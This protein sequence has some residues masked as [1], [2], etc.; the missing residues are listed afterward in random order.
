[1]IEPL[2]DRPSAFR[3]EFRILFDERFLYIGVMAYD[4]AGARGVRVEDLRRKFDFFQNDLAGITLDPLADG[5]NSVSF[6]VTPYGAQ[7]ELQTF[8][9]EFFN[10]EWEGVWR[11]RA[12][13]S[14]SGWSGELRIPWQTLRYRADGTPWGMNLLRIARR[15]NEQ[16]AWAPYPR[17]FTVYRMDYAGRLTG[18]EPPPPRTDVQLRPYVLADAQRT[19][20]P[21]ERPRDSFDPSIGGEIIWR[22]TTSLQVEGTV[23]TDFAQADVDRQVVNL[24][25]FSVFFPERRQFFLEGAS[26]FDAGTDD[27]GLPIRPF[28]SRTIGLDAAGT[29]IPIQGGV[30]ALWRGA[31]G[32]AGALLLRQAGRDT[33][34]PATFGVLR[35][36]RNL[37]AATRVGAMLTSR[38]DEGR[39]RGDAVSHTVAVDGFS[40]FGPT[41]NLEW[42]LSAASN[43]LRDRRGVGWHSFIGRQTDALYTGLLFTGAT[44]GY[45]PAMG[46]VGRSD[47]AMV[48]PGVI[49][50]FRPAWRPAALRGFKPGGYFNL[51]LGP[52]DGRIQEGQGQL[53][54]DVVFVN[55]TVIYPYV[56]PNLQR[57]TQPVPFVGE[58]TIAPGRQDYVRYGINVSTNRSARL[59]TR[60]DASTGGF[61]NGRQDRLDLTLRWAPRPHVSLLAN[62]EVNR[63]RD[64]GAPARSLTTHLA[65]P[66]L[67]LAWNPRLQ[68]SSFYQYSSVD[69]RGVFNG[70]FSWEFAPL[71]YLFVV[72]NDRRQQGTLPPTLQAFPQSNELL[73]KLVYLWQ[74]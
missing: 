5:R 34:G 59:S 38:V 50:D 2:Q 41:V 28:F 12:V 37:G 33:T 42:M 49:W 51:Y 66:E 26:V 8:D 3:T 58:L 10:R 23:R 72:Y 17:N 30:R 52:R 14:D 18:L 70:R 71:S 6:Q 4:T 29:P 65:G 31:G 56:E 48:S 68:L 7:R 40:R 20:A 73:V 1:M 24:R 13:R 47:V 21:G 44:R 64:V 15:A 22:P 32:N 39:G 16:S 9:G 36:T 25:R 55:G 54:V 46:F 27:P 61:F 43:E 45:D 67:R 35:G 63:L 53:Y 19:T 69:R 60:F 62:Y 11:A 57:P 74:R